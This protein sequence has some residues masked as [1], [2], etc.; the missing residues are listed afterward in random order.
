MMDE[1]KI[2]CLICPGGGLPPYLEKECQFLMASQFYTS[3]FN[4]LDFPT[5]VI[6]E[7]RRVQK[8]DL[9]EPYHD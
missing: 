1:L 3:L 7:V 5:G 9:L 6:P 4:S 2:D 8:E